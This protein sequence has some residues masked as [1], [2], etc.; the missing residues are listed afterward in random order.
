M[1]ARP[2]RRFRRTPDSHHAFP[3]A[4]NLINQ[5]FSAERPNQNWAAA[6]SYLWTAEGWLYLAVIL[7][8]FSRRVVGWALSDRLHKEWALE[9]LAKVLAIRRPGTGLIP[10]SDR[11]SQYGSLAYQAKLTKHALQISMA[12]KGNCYD[13]AVV[14]TFFKTLK[15]EWV[16]RTVFQSRA[17]ARDAIGR[18]IAIQPSTSSVPSN[19]KGRADTP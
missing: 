11:A 15:T 13:H 19:S 1:N 3:I 7:D 12:G 18:Y 5:D 9:A 6:I 4:P 8:L 10:H 16:W 17:E 2:K 14:E